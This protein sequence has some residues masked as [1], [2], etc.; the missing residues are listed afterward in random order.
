MKIPGKVKVGYKVYD[1]RL[2]DNPVVDGTTVLYGQTDHNSLTTRV[3]RFY[4]DQQSEATFVHELLHDI[5]Y[6]Y[7]LGLSEDII[8]RLGNALYTVMVDNPGIF[9]SDDNVNS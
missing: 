3:S 7:T 9:G 1:V 2:L 4:G 5:D 8:E 6:M